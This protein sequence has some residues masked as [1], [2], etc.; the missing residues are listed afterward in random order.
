MTPA[1]L[2]KVYNALDNS[3]K[4]Q[5][6]RIVLV[7]EQAPG[8]APVLLDRADAAPSRSHVTRSSAPSR[9]VGHNV[10]KRSRLTVE[11]RPGALAVK[12][13]LQESQPHTMEGA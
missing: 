1:E 2:L 10:R 8:A 12:G 11:V 3:R 13:L 4:V 9:H 5:P 6:L 7:D